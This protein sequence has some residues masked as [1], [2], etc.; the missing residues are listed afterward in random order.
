M[1]N[2]VNLQKKSYDYINSLNLPFN[3]YIQITTHNTID[4]YLK[5]LEG[6]KYIRL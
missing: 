6:S 2:T 3:D 1:E 4:I 5:Y